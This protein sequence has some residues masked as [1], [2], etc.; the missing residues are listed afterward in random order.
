MFHNTKRARLDSSVTL[1]WILIDR[2]IKSSAYKSEFS[3]VPFG[4]TNGSHNVFLNK[5]QG[6]LFI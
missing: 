3:S 6:K 4:R 5:Y 1:F 2:I